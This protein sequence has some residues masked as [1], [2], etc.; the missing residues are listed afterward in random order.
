MAAKPLPQD[1]KNKVIADWRTGE[2]SQRDLADKYQISTG[3]A[4]KLCKGVNQD[5]SAIVSAGI[6]Y[7]QGLEP[8]DEQNVSAI[9]SAVDRIIQQREFFTNNTIRNLSLMMDKVNEGSTISEHAIAQNALARGKETVLGKQPETQVNI[10]NNA[11]PLT[12]IVS[13]EEYEEINAK[14]NDQI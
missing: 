12:S 6:Q 11:A 8:L 10:Q 3:A 5:T 7:R 9:M 13:L 2:Y 14:F 1:I 4:A